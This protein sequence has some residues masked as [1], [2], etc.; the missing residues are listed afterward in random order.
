MTVF[1]ASR[2]IPHS[3]ALSELGRLALAF[4]DG[5]PE[6]L[7][8]AV[9]NPASQ[10]DFPDETAF[11]AGVQQGLHASPLTL[12][13]RLGLLVSPVKLM[14]LGL[15]DLRTLARA[16]GG[17]T[18]AVVAVQ[19]GKILADQGLLTQAD[20]GAGSAFLAEAGVATAPVF[21]SMALEDQLAVHGLLRL[22][23]GQNA[24]NL[25]LQKEAAAFGAKQAR[26]PLEF[27]DYY[28]CFLHHT[29]KL[30]ALNDTAERRAELAEQALQTLLPLL[31][32]ALDCPQVAGLAAAAEVSQT[33]NAWIARGRQI[34]FA[35]LSQGVQQIIQYTNFES[36]TGEAAKAVVT[37]YLGAAQSLLATAQPQR[38]ALRQD[39]ACLR[40]PFQSGE[41]QA[42]LELAA[43]GS[44]T[45]S[46]FQKAPSARAKPKPAPAKNG[47][48]TE[49][50]P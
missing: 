7:A 25:E 8:W 28:K 35:R 41:Q 22:S 37:G 38:G 32:G 26:T 50:A 44:I 24:Q 12:L 6:W 5:G 43:S 15:A 18:S 13:P 34:G 10:Y 9:A 46:R 47:S 39:G 27:V 23:E 42:E 48:N 45:L 30:G 49:V 1:V 31:F 29:A 3:G 4:V 14:A 16:E 2:H 21:Q 33:V 11:V 40:L 17:D 19:T 20:L 36:E